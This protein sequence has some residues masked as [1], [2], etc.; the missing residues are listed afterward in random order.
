MVFFY[1]NRIFHSQHTCW[2][3]Y[4]KGYTSPVAPTWDTYRTWGQTLLHLA[5]IHRLPGTRALALSSR[6]RHRKVPPMGLAIIFRHRQRENGNRLDHG[7]KGPKT[8]PR[9]PTVKLV[10][11]TR[12]RRCEQWEELPTGLGL[13][14]T[15]NLL[16]T[17]SKP[18]IQYSSLLFWQKVRFYTNENVTCSLTLLH[19]CSRRA[20]LHGSVLS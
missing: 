16:W 15:W 5:D 9:F 14:T 11:S 19:A 3:D 1:G 8:H 2:T 17:W 20:S 4:E 6:N 12:G 7:Q 13:K 10:K 18:H